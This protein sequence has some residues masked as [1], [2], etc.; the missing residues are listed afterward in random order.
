MIQGHGGNIGKL[1]RTLQCSSD[2]IIDMSSNLNPLGPPENIKDVIVDNFV[3]IQSLPEV[4]AIT[5]R[6]GFAKFHGIDHDNVVAGNGTTWFI[7][8][9]PKALEAKKVLI[10]GPTYS[11]YK[12]ACMMHGIKFEHCHSKAANMFDLDI[13][14]V[15]RLA[16]LSDMVFICNPNNP[17]G[18]L[19][20]KD[21]LEYL[22]LKHKDTIFI[23]DESYLPFVENAR[24]ISL[25]ANTRYNNL[26]VLTSMSKIFRIP[27]LRTGFLSA[28]KNLIEKIMVYYQPWS[29]NALA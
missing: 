17:T 23:I 24:D 6:K 5:M 9:I 15:S 22:I 29:V 20:S 3:S 7:Y 8:T 14:E 26:I 12:D 16:Q 25:V 11:D 27:G 19:I 1:A 13:D 21:K 28:K 10:T 18:T 4:D 2:E